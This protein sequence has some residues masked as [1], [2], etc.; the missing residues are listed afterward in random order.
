MADLSANVIHKTRGSTRQSAPIANGV[1]LYEGA[2]VG[3]EGG[4]AN[5]W[6]DGANDVFAGIVLG[7]GI[8]I[9]PGAALLGNTSATPIPEV[10]IDTSGVTLMHL[11]SIDG[12]PTQAKVGD[13]VYGVSSNTDDLDLTAV[14][15]NNTPVGWLSY[16]RSATDSDVTL[17]T[18][19][20][21][22]AYVGT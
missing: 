10:Q 22:L 20:E 5:H 8:G 19:S 9:A 1:T 14:T 15:A 2:L 21:F 11:D 3:W 13:I 6:A 18:P 17:F 4:Y 16:F 7:A 12:T